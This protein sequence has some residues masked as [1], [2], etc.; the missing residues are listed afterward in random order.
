VNVW[1]V[2]FDVVAI[3]LVAML[4]LAAPK[5]WRNEAGP[6]TDDSPPP[7][8]WSGWKRSRA[9]WRGIVRL[10]GLAMPLA[11]VP[12]LLIIV[13]ATLGASGPA[14][15]AV[16]IVVLGAATVFMVTAM[17]AVFLFNRPRWLV[18]PHLRHQ[19]GYIAERFN[20]THVEPTPPP[21][22]RGQLFTFRR[23]S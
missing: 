6:W 18:A 22:R 4:V 9:G 5:L 19:P 15:D 14:F 2:F 12:I 23:R 7:R 20:G 10:L 17:P 21:A 16:A 3:A 13:L 1:S 8:S 11:Y